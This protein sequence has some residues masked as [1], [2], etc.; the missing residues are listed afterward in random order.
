VRNR[1]LPDDELPPR[2]V[3]R[4]HK[5]GTHP[6]DELSVARQPQAPLSRTPSAPAPGALMGADEVETEVAAAHQHGCI[7]SDRRERQGPGDPGAGRSSA[8]LRSASEPSLVGV[9]K[10]RQAQAAHA[11]RAAA[12]Q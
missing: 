2:R 11:R 3:R 10:E 7:T 9:A 1:T 12:W 4:V 5:R 8:V 6:A